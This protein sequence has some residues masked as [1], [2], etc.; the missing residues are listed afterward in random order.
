[1]RNAILFE[2][3]VVE[4]EEDENGSPVFE[5]VDVGCVRFHEF[6]VNYDQRDDGLGAF[7]SAIVEHPDGTLENVPVEMLQFIRDDI[8]L[9]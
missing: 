8:T 2:Y 7:S 1:M 6:G 5:R 3:K 4:G 9:N